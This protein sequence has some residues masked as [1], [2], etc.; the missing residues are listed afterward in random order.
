MIPDKYPILSER[1][2]IAE[3]A[4]LNYFNVLAKSQEDANT[5]MIGYYAA[6]Q[7]NDLRR[8]YRSFYVVHTEPG[9]N[10]AQHW[11][12]TIHN[13][14]DVITPERCAEELEKPSKDSL[15]DFL[16]WAMEPK[17]KGNDAGVG[18]EDGS[19]SDAPMD[20]SPVRGRKEGR[21]ASRWQ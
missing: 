19:M 15:F 4:P 21:R 11:K 18:S 17:E 3:L 12:D 6:L 5:S 7:S 13:I 8:H 9:A 16:D 2:Q 14:S 10:C 20:I 1:R